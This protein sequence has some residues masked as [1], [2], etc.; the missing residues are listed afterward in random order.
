MN[1]RS[2]IPTMRGF[3][4]I[5]L[6]VTV[7]IIAILAA[8]AYPSFVEQIRKSRR[9]DAKTALTT[10]VQNIERAYT[11]SN[12]YASAVADVI[13]ASA[14]SPENY[15]DVSPVA[16]SASA[17]TFKL[18]A[19]PKGAQTGD[20]CGTFTLDSS[21]NKGVTGGTTTDPKQCW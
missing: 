3:T 12:S 16:A 11:L 17:S 10:Q 20:R 13:G 14:T 21:N 4:L 15:Y 18:Q 9:T 6:M 5:E 19:T 8:I 1:H 7:A 2:H